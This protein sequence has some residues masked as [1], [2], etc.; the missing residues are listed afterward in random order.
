MT[1]TEL[2]RNQAL[3]YEALRDAKS[4]LS[5]YAILDSL[6]ES[7][8]RAPQQV[9]RALDKL[10]ELGLV[11]RIESLNAFVACCASEAHDRETTAFSICESCGDV[12]E[13]TDPELLEKLDRL[14]ANSRFR[15][16]RA[17]LELRGLCPDC[18]VEA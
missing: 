3:V 9:Y 6:R 16:R 1:Q 4:A 2:T 8:L 5:A 14:S 11:H 17:S 13:L 18:A 12:G 10:Q 7:G 15:T